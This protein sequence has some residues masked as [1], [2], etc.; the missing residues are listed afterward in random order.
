MKIILN[1]RQ[2]KIFDDLRHTENPIPAKIFAS[3]YNVSLRTVRN[4]INIISDFVNENGATIIKLPKIGM[5]IKN[6]NSI[7]FSSDEF[8]LSSYAYFSSD[9]KNLA[10][11]LYFLLNKNPITIEQMCNVL[12]ISKGTFINGVDSL[13]NFFKTNDIKIS[14]IGKK[15]KGYFLNYTYQSLIKALV[16]FRYIINSKTIRK[17]IYLNN[18]LVNDDIKEKELLLENYSKNNCSITLINKNTFMSFICIFFRI[19]QINNK[20][21]NEKTVYNSILDNLIFKIEKIINRKINYEESLYIKFIYE[22]Y[23]DYQ[24]DLHYS[25]D[26]RD[27]SEAIDLMIEEM[28]KSY[29][30]LFLNKESLSSEIIV[31]LLSNIKRKQLGLDN[32]N[33][34]INEIK[35]RFPDLFENTKKATNSFNEKYKYSFDDDE[36]GYLTLYFAKALDKAKNTKDVKLILICNTGRGSS[37][38]LATRILNN[39]PE[40]HIIGMFS[41]DDAIMESNAYKEADL[42]ISTFKLDNIDKPT[43]V[44]SPIL[45]EQELFNIKRAI[46]SETSYSE[47]SKIRTIK[48][49]DDSC[50]LYSEVVIE[51]LA[52]LSMIYK[53]GLKQSDFNVV[54]GIVSHTIMSIP[55]WK[56]SEF[57]KASDYETLIKKHKKEY[58]IIDEFLSK[59]ENLLNVT[60]DRVEIIAIMRYIFQ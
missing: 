16:Q 33:P 46:H 43:L 4:D 39:L 45:S 8:K 7:V 32:K 19:A 35:A 23:T 17:I 10:I 3:K 2:R 31:H 37:R 6:A 52:M 53:N 59:M 27:L 40:A 24:D 26:K 30:D 49:E 12:C 29:G 55:R 28:V 48:S 9:V 38:L 14:I 13:N 44:V 20:K 51:I 58:D 25:L 15:N 5:Q 54:A 47:N 56:K 34:L 36:I 22:N 41:S 50:L 57:I 21:G 1:E 42:I 60:I 18:E 11:F